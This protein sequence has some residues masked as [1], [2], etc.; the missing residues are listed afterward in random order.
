MQSKRPVGI[1]PLPLPNPQQAQHVE[2]SWD[3]VKQQIQV[4]R[5][6]LFSLVSITNIS[7]DPVITN[8][9]AFRRAEALAIL[10]RLL[11]NITGLDQAIQQIAQAV[12]NMS[13]PVNFDFD[14]QSN[15]L[16]LS[17]QVSSQLHDWMSLFET[18]IG[19]DI[20]ALVGL[21]S[22]VAPAGYVIAK[23][24]LPH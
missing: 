3:Q 24:F 20:D 8:N 22:E 19:S 21:Y 5:S 6:A 10:Q 1:P 18:L 23:P 9:P 17:F 4:C 15:Q 7:R 12:A 2:L 11:P 16:M 13:G 14:A